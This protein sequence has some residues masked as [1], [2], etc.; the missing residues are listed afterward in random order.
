M[1]KEI[2]INKY[3]PIAILYFFFNGF[4]LP[5]G[6]LYT[7]LLTPLFLIWLYRYP[8]FNYLWLFFLVSLPFVAVHLLNGVDV[9]SYLKSYLLLF[10]VFVFCLAFYQFLRLCKTLH[11][12]YNKLTIINFFFVLFA[13]VVFFIPFLKD[14]VWF[15]TIM[16]SGVDRVYR[17]KLFTYEASYYSFLLA[18]IAIYFYLKIALFRFPNKAIVFWI[19][20][21][22][23]LLSLSFGVLAAIIIALV[24]LFCSDLKLI[25]FNP[26]LPRYVLYG[27]LAVV[28]LLFV[29]IQ[30]FPDNVIFTRIENVFKGRDTSF[31]GRTFDSLYLGWEVAAQKSTFFGSGPGQTKVLAL[32]LFNKYYNHSFATGQLTIPNNIGDILAQFGL[33]G[34]LIKLSL[35]GYFFF[36]TKVYTNYYR[37]CLFLFIFIYQFTGSFI[38]NITEYVIWLLAFYPLLFPEFNKKNVFASQPGS[39]HVLQ[40]SFP[41]NKHL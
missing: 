8:S 17:L 16:T 24:L 23:L 27:L 13:A 41:L 19:I 32:D 7:A 20:T 5:I 14:T 11:D 10:S 25:T 15:G 37:L 6:L 29:I 21:I 1:D 9:L 33:L 40:P 38:T 39:I 30:F 31:S 34:V 26:K 3:L 2:K 35:E 12:I 4:L 18:P 28:G 22:P 36:K